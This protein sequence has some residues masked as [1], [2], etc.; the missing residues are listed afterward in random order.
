MVLP[1]HGIL[2]SNKK[3]ANYSHVLLSN[4]VVSYR[5]SICVSGLMDYA[6]SLDVCSRLEHLGFCNYI[7]TLHN[8][9]ITEVKLLRM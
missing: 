1:Y 7:V 6:V 2:L 3:E 8:D 9:K 4:V 5:V